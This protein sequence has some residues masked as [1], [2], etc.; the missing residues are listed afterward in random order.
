MGLLATAVVLLSP[1]RGEQQEEATAVESESAA[2]LP[3]N[4]QILKTTTNYKQEDAPTDVSGLIGEIYDR[5]NEDLDDV[6]KLDI[7]Y[8]GGVIH[9]LVGR[10]DVRATVTRRKENGTELQECMVV[11]VVIEDSNECTLPERHPMHHECHASA[12]CVNTIGSYECSC[13]GREACVPRSG[14]GYCTGINSSADCC[15]V[16]EEKRPNGCRDKT[17]SHDCRRDFR[18]YTDQCEGKC[19]YPDSCKSSRGMVTCACQNESEV[20]NGHVCPG[21]TPEVLTDA[22]GAFLADLDPSKV[23]GCQVPKVDLCHDVSCGQHATCSEGKCQCAPGY[24]HV[25]DLGCMDERPV[26]LDLKG[27]THL[28]MKQCDKYVEH[29]VQVV[30]AN[31]ENHDRNV[32]VS[33]SKPPG[34]CASEM[35]TFTVN[36][37]LNTEWMDPPVQY[38]LRHVTVEDV[39]ECAL[40]IG[41]PQAAC[42]GCKP[43]CHKHARC[44]NRVGT[45]TCQCP[46]CMG[47]DGFEPFTPRK[48]GT[49]PAGYDGGTGCKDT[50]APV[51]TLIGDDPLVMTVGLNTDIAGNPIRGKDYTQ[52]LASLITRTAGGALCNDGLGSRCATVIDN[53]GTHQGVDITHNLK[54]LEPEPSKK[55]P[56]QWKVSYNAVDEAG[57]YALPKTRTI[58]IK[59]VSMEEYADQKVKEAMK[60]CPKCGTGKPTECPKPPAP[61]QL[62]CKPSEGEKGR[63]AGNTASDISCSRDCPCSE[64]RECVAESECAARLEE[65]KQGHSATCQKEAG[66]WFFPIILTG[67]QQLAVAALVLLATGVSVFAAVH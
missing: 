42:Y 5:V 26:W 52:E 16:D 58:E 9:R 23:C 31:S 20:G 60:N 22:S 38:I 35:G 59:E 54:I 62:P 2:E 53:N 55:D 43:S 41:S 27:P 1:S 18:C 46:A 63:S 29:G 57:N 50:C 17:C 61:V 11:P 67:A 64:R 30:D 44:E 3:E 10:H 34:K 4:C 49:L 8:V 65:Q 24:S 56:L 45:Y 47:G 7:N 66:G 48:S 28:T 32:G 19:V 36:Y 12:E 37:T 21:E 15:T 25:P 14:L 6:L 40:D 39:D 13:P 51:I 33:Y